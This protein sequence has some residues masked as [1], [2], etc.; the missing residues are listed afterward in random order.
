MNNILALHTEQKSVFSV[1]SGRIQSW[2]Y[3]ILLKGSETPAEVSQTFAMLCP[4]FD[5]LKQA[6]LSLI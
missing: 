6:G 2:I 3:R 1:S 4:R 5:S